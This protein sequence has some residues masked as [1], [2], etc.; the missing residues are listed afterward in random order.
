MGNQNQVSEFAEITGIIDADSLSFTLMATEPL[1][2][3]LKKGTSDGFMPNWATAARKPVIYP[4]AMSQLEGIRKSIVAA[5]EEWTYNGTVIGFN[6][7]GI[8]ATPA[9]IANVFQKVAH[10]NGDFNVPG[11]KIISNL[12]SPTNVDTDSVGMSCKVEVSGIQVPASNA[13][14]VRLEETVGDPYQGF[15]SATDGGVIDSNTRSVTLTAE[16]TKAGNYVTSGVVY[17][18]TKAIMGGWAAFPAI[19]AT[20]NKANVT[21][22]DVDTFAL[23]KCEYIIDG[24]VVFASVIK[25][26]DETDPLVLVPNPSGPTT[27]GRGGSITYRPKVVRRA[28]GVVEPS[29]N[30]VSFSTFKTDGTP[31]VIPSGQIVSNTSIQIT[32][33]DVDNGGGKIRIHFLASK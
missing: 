20:P 15:I 26:P 14:P 16:L 25:V 7:S 18:W 13:I 32:R 6:A 9:S 22:N 2:Q 31:I 29:Y 8:S 3:Y 21:A 27:L 19:P 4:N 23:F 12:V 24:L 10:N 28:T 5:S 30:K 11:L 1:V 33:T 17:R